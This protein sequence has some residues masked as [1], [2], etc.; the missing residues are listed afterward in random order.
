MGRVFL[1]V[2][3]G[4][5]C[6]EKCAFG[7]HKIAG[8]LKELPDNQFGTIQDLNQC[9]IRHGQVNSAVCSGEDGCVGR[10]LFSLLEW[11][12]CIPFFFHEDWA[13]GEIGKNGEAW[14]QFRWRFGISGLRDQES[15][16]QEG[17]DPKNGEKFCVGEHI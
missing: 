3:L 10:N 16:W 13:A 9:A 8:I 4:F 12:R 1:R 7:D 17:E 2:D 11:A 5:L 6:E 15:A 14:F